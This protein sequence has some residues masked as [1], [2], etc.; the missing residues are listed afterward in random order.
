MDSRKQVAEEFCATVFD[1]LFIRPRDW[2][3]KQAEA[4]VDAT[5]DAIIP[6]LPRSRSAALAV[7]QKAGLGLK[8]DA[9]TNAWPTTREVLIAIRG[10][11]NDGASQDAGDSGW[12]HR[13]SDL[14]LETTE[15]WLRDHKQ[16][17][18]WMQMEHPEKVAEA[19]MARGFS[20]VELDKLGYR[21]KNGRRPI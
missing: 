16:W 18:D 7:V 21:A 13:N 2:S 10:A 15:R 3:D 11:A 12:P 9:R 4:H 5:V 1:A 6:A 19:M 14:I 8:A 20:E 17:P